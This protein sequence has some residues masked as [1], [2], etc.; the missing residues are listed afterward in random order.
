MRK[1]WKNLD[2]TL[3]FVPLVL[4][5]FGIVMVYSSSMLFAYIEYGSSTYF[6]VKQIQWV[7]IGSFFYFFTA[8]IPY[9]KY[10][11][12]IKLMV[13]VLL[14]L[15]V[16]V[17]FFGD[18]VNNARSWYSFGFFSFQPAEVAKLGLIMYLA[19]VFSKKINYIDQF[20]KAV[21]P[22][23]ILTFVVL[24][25][26]MMQPDFGT[27][28]IIFLIAGTVVLASGIRLRH[29]LMIIM[30]LV[31]LVIALLPRVI[32]DERTERFTGAYDPFADHL[33]SGYQLIQSYV[34]IGT[35]GLTGVG[36]GNSVQKLGYLQEAHTDF[37]M[38]IIAEE[39]GLIG[40]SI[41]IG[42]LATIV[43]RGLYIAR[44]C[45]D[46][47]G[48]LLAIGISSMIG[49]QTFINIGSMSGILPI[50]GVTLPFVSYGGSSLIILMVSVGIL[51]NIAMQVRM[52]DIPIR[53]SRKSIPKGQ[54]KGQNIRSINQYRKVGRI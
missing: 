31:M 15:L 20:N 51:N 25:L 53:K 40:V 13:I 41:V 26:I 46:A 45:E 14:L 54:P 4:A 33:N 50:T 27:A 3:L 24:G 2:F 30:A 5:G 22:P 36:L 52:K 10:Q 35:G 34:A 47:F 9:Q 48:S 18:L 42:L 28:A 17:L 49:I 38:A 39:L 44:K 29:L 8:F 23:L 1:R 11:K 19:S 21:V 12:L 7:L 6:L 32:S 16:G 37:I 43:L